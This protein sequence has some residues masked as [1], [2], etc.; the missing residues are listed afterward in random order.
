MTR[1]TKRITIDEVNPLLVKNDF[2]NPLRKLRVCAYARVSS[3][4]EDQITSYNNQVCYYTDY[5]QSNPN[6][7]FVDVFTDEGISGTN[8]FK[9]TGFN[10]M[11]K[12]CKQGKID[13]I[14]TKS[15]SRFARN[16]VDSLMTCRMLKERGIGVFFEKENLNTLE[17]N[18]ELHLTIAS[19]VAQE[20]SRSISENVKWGYKAKF[21]RGEVML[22]TSRFLGYDRDENGELIINEAEARIVRRI[23]NLFLK[24]LNYRE[25]ANILTS[26]RVPTVTGKDVW[27]PSVIRSI[28]GNEKY[29]G[30]C[31][32]QKSYTKDFLTH[33]RVKNNGEVRKYI[34]E[35][36]HEA[37]VPKEIFI[38]VQERMADINDKWKQKR[39]EKILNSKY[40][41]SN[42][43]VCGK[44]GSPM[45]RKSWTKHNGDIEVRYGCKERLRKGVKC[46]SDYIIEDNLK[47]ALV[48]SINSYRNCQINEKSSQTTLDIDDLQNK[49]RQIEEEINKL[50]ETIKLIML[51][52]DNEDK[53]IAIGTK[54]KE[55]KSQR[56][57][58]NNEYRRLKYQNDL[59]NIENMNI[60]LKPITE[61]DETLIRKL[62]NKIVVK[63][64]EEIEVQ[65]KG[66]FVIK[67]RM[68]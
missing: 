17:D 55:Y 46:H 15:V 36:S 14:I 22:V 51:D 5:I 11:I 40:V 20:E 61:Y 34:V 19:S 3:D 60:N 66:G 1:A 6:W 9:R 62:I 47:H 39:G 59:K 35:N 52:P 25:I 24:G 43:L 38:A 28:L 68:N 31:I 67:Q 57:D 8:T 37:I 26:E 32:N 29:A 13:L 63:N 50:K 27:N 58:L 53:L 2:K 44:C 56:D 18:I 65:F 33:K 45:R 49:I 23:F 64:K 12:M 4:G 41:L 42:L 21:E 10:K 48:E 16:T 7:I 54:M 30:N